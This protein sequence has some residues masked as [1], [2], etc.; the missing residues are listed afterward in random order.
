MSPGEA[1][2]NF[3]EECERAET[4]GAV[5]N[6]FLEQMNGLGFDY[7]ALCSHVDPLNPPPAAISVFRYPE[8]WL[9]H[10]SSEGYADIDP[11]FVHANRSQTPFFWGDPAFQIKLNK[12]QKRVA[13]LCQVYA[14]NWTCSSC[15]S[16]LPFS[17]MPS[18]N[19]SC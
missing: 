15:F 6:A 1:L 8:F 7:V 11:V 14:A 9:K 17:S 13:K 4:A 2:W 19:L 5:A 16:F 18:I 10:F 12:K 3:M